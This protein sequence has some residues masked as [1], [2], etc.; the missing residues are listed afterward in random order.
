MDEEEVE[1]AEEEEEGRLVEYRRRKSILEEVLQISFS[2]D[3]WRVKGMK[4]E[5]RRRRGE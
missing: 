1:E 2:P 3:M 4:G 5:T